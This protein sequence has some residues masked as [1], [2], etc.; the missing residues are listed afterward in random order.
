LA[1]RESAGGGD[2]LVSFY[3]YV[4]LCINQEDHKER[5]HQVGL[6][7]LI[8]SMAKEVIAWIGPNSTDSSQAMTA[9]RKIPL[10]T[11]LTKDPP[12]LWP[13]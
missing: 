6:M 2:L 12:V 10:D 7:K 8:Y 1:A 13:H 3:W 5:S 11:L 4:A 9:L